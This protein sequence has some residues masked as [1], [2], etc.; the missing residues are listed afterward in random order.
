MTNGVLVKVT[1]KPSHQQ[2][3]QGGITILILLREKVTSE[4]ALIIAVPL[5]HGKPAVCREVAILHLTLLQMIT[6]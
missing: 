4:S 2:R 6:N 3:Q 1:K 5:L